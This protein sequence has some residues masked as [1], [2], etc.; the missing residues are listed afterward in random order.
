MARKRNTPV[1]QRRRVDYHVV[2]TEADTLATNE[3]VEKSV[4]A[5]LCNKGRPVLLDALR[6]IEMSAEGP[7][8][9][10]RS[11]GSDVHFVLLKV[12]TEK[13]ADYDELVDTIEQALIAGHKKLKLCGL[14][15]EF[16][17]TH[18]TP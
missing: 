3:D 18:N 15:A 6:R 5:A 8:Q 4:G 9:V 12:V 11:N 13:P 7:V 10:G 14:K 16:L 17:R 2:R 1:A